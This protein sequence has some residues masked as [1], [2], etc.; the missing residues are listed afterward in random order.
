M[1][2]RSCGKEIRDDANFCPHCGHGEISEA[3]EIPVKVDL[4][5]IQLKAEGFIEKVGF[6]K[7]AGILSGATAGLNVVIRFFQAGRA[8]ILI[9]TILH[10]LLSATMLYLWKKKG[11]ALELKPILI[12][13]A[14]ALISVIALF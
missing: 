10:L 11:Y 4:A 13:W 7:F 2:C 8:W 9:I 6:S 14:A 1:F 12:M 5:D 3:K